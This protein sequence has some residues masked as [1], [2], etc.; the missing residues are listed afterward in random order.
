MEREAFNVSQT[1]QDMYIRAAFI[2][3]DLPVNLP[4]HLKTRSKVKL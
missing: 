1:G 2:D 4:D 3:T